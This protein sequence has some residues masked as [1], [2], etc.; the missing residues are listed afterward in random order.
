MNDIIVESQNFDCFVKPSNKSTS[1]FYHVISLLYI[2]NVTKMA[3]LNTFFDNKLVFIGNSIEILRIL[4]K[5]YYKFCKVSK[6]VRAEI[7]VSVHVHD[8]CVEKT[9]M[10]FEWF[11]VFVR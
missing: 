9:K 2:K 11:V 7:T 6:G 3:S 5:L 1:Q 10:T 8:Q 4:T